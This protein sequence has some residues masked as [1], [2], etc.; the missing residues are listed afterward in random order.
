MVGEADGIAGPK[1]T[2]AVTEFQAD[3]QCC[4]DGEITAG[5]K[6]WKILLGVS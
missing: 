6:T 5:N 1:F 4:I 2:S 3:N